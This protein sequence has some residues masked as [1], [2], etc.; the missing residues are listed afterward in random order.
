MIKLID[1]TVGRILKERAAQ[2]AE[3]V[4]ITETVSGRSITYGEFDK[5]TDIIA[6]AML[7]SGLEKGDHIG[8]MCENGIRYVEL[9]LAAAK[10]GVV[11]VPININYFVSEISRVL[12]HA[13]IKML[14]IDPYF[15]DK[16]N[17]KLVR[18]AWAE[19]KNEI[20]LE[21][22]I[23]ADDDLAEDKAAEFLR[24]DA[25]TAYAS[26]VSP[27]KLS[28]VSDSVN[29]DDLYAI[30]YTSGT[31]A[32]PKGVM[33]R[34]YAVIN[35]CRYAV[36][37]MGMNSS[38]KLCT[39]LP[40]FTTFGTVVAILM[41]LI[42]G[43][44]LL[45]IDCFSPVKMLSAVEKYR[46]TM[47]MG[48]PTMFI[49]MINLAEF[50]DYDHS[51]VKKAVIGGAISS[52]ALMRD[53]HDSFGLEYITGIYGMTEMSCG[54]TISVLDTDKTRQLTTVGKSFDNM[55]I[56]VVDENNNEVPTGMAGEIV[57]KGYHVMRGYYKDPEMTAKAIDRDGWLHSGDLGYVDS[58]G[59]FTIIGR[60]KH[61]IIKGGYNIAPDEISEKIEEHDGVIVA[62]VVGV[63]DKVY[64][65]EIAAFVQTVSSDIDL[66]DVRS[67]L[68]GK[69]AKYKI[70]KYF[71]RVDGFEYSPGGKVQKFR[72]EELAVELV[73]KGGGI[74]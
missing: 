23:L 22:V 1:T 53:I 8:I 48:V 69:I 33:L 10:I 16:E 70:P 19:Q 6:G 71:F 58:E 56:R 39:P 27:E 43:A 61:I 13:D 21:K 11:V 68:T 74:C 38:D 50:A 29:S 2:L 66:G 42:S 57:T 63:K 26:L 36:H 20:M 62:E 31:T 12:R 9:V 52:E 72:L 7:G 14:F 28:G 44:D 17:W 46:A 45:T 59:Y 37:G 30:M 67:S 5:S 73:K 15:R 35:S 3:S 49:N 64:G 55:L 51:S 32:D 4:F 54:C 25:F 18:Q 40:L 65:E 41:T 60:K 47:M 34:Q 24:W